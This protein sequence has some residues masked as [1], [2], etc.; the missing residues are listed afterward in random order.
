M[1]GLD[2]PSTNQ[3][4]D[5]QMSQKGIVPA[6]VGLAM[7]AF[8]SVQAWAFIEAS[9]DATKADLDATAMVETLRSE[10]VDMECE[11]RMAKLDEAFA[12][13]RRSFG[14]QSN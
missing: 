8:A 12:E 13:S 1:R 7:I 2:N 5:G 11:K 10:L 6:L 14:C 4:K 3:N 9:S